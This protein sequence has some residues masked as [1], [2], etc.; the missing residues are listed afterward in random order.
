MENES[1]PL[2]D[3]QPLDFTFGAPYESRHQCVAELAYDL[4]V[5]RGRPLG[6]PNVDWLAAERYL[7]ESLQ[8]SG[9]ISG[10][11][12]NGQSIADVLYNRPH[13]SLEW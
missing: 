7:Y 3:G 1:H 11:R 5:R 2:D 8:A 13:S 9:V 6:S 4:W 12:S 10:S